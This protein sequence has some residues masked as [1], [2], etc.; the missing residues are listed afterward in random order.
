MEEKV[1]MDETGTISWITKINCINRVD[2]DFH[3]LCSLK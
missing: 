1:P 2:R 3:I